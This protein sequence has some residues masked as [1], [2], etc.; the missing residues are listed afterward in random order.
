MSHK[1]NISAEEEEARRAHETVML[2]AKR[3]TGLRDNVRSDFI[4]T[5]SCGHPISVGFA[6]RHM[7]CCAVVYQEQRLKFPE[8]RNILVQY[9]P[10]DSLL[11]SH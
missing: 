2:F 9:A 10:L 7:V 6:W 3:Y 1:R 5:C 4:G 11:S 8:L